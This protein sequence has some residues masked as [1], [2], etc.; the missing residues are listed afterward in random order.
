MPGTQKRILRNSLILGV[1]LTAGAYAWLQRWNVA[2]AVL[3]G[4]LAMVINFWLLTQVIRS[5]VQPDDDTPKWKIVVRLLAKVG[6]LF[7][8]L[9]FLLF[10]PELE[11]LALLAGVSTV[12]LAI[13]LE[14]FLPAI[15][16]APADD[17]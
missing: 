6:F 7:G 17:A 11:P 13:M 5:F 2:L 8:L 1:V 10:G 16:D 14:G 3:L 9:A 15:D 4:A 12:V